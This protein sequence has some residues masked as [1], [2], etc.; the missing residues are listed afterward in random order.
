MAYKVDIKLDGHGIIQECQC[1]CTAGTGPNA[2]CKHV[3]LVYYAITKVSE[4]IKTKETC[5]QQLQSFHQ[6]KKY[7]GSPVKMQDTKGQSG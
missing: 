6:V 2:H 3:G 7:N 4:G 1:Q 5:T